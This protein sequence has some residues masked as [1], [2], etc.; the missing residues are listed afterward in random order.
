M[1]HSCSHRLIIFL[2]L[3]SILVLPIRGLAFAFDAPADESAGHKAPCHMGDVD[4]EDA[5]VPVSD[6]ADSCCGDLVTGCSHCFMYMGLHTPLQVVTVAHSH[7]S[8]NSLHPQ[9]NTLPPDSLFRPP[10][11]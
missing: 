7:T 10:R 2:T 8:P 9:L 11:S 5:S 3:V 1:H 6:P 4:L